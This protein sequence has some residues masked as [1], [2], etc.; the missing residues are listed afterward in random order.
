MRTH[1]AKCVERYLVQ[2]LLSADFLFYYVK[3]MLEGTDAVVLPQADGI[4]M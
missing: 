3:G 1:D 2:L 4:E